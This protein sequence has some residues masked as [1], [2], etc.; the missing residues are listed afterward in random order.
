MKDVN[1]DSCTFC[2]KEKETLT[3]VFAHCEVVNVFWQRFQTQYKFV[4]ELNAFSKCFGILDLNADH[5]TLVNQILILMRRYIYN[6]RMSKSDLSLDG[7]KNM[8]DDTIKL[9]YWCAQR[10]A[11]LNIHFKKWD[12]SFIIK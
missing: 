2:K 11:K 8:I 4:P 7:F 3:H 1:N 9:E 5:S 6:C 10:K 12:P